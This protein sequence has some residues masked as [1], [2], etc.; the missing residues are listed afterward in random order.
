MAAI[1][2]RNIMIRRLYNKITDYI[3]KHRYKL[4]MDELQKLGLRNQKLLDCPTPTFIIHGQTFSFGY[5]VRNTKVHESLIDDITTHVVALSGAGATV[6]TIQVQNKVNSLLRD[7]KCMDDLVDILK[8]HDIKVETIIDPEIFNSA[9]PM[10][11]IGLGLLKDKHK[12]FIQ[13]LN[14]SKVLS[15]LVD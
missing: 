5:P 15:I 10:S 12:D 2:D 1:P 4:S 8:D 13:L 7:I 14:E 3:T 11:A 9:P 6:Q